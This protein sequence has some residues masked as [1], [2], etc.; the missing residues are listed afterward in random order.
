MIVK[1]RLLRWLI[2]I[3][4]AF[5]LFSALVLSFAIFT[6]LPDRIGWSALEKAVRSAGGTVTARREGA[7]ISGL[8][9]YDFDLRVP[10][11]MSLRSRR[12]HLRLSPWALVIGVARI[13]DLKVEAPD[14]SITP[15]PPSPDSKP[16]RN[17][18]WLRLLIP[19]LKVIDGRVTVLPTPGSGGSPSQWSG[20]QLFGNL[21]VESQRLRLT[22]TELSVQCPAPCPPALTVRGFVAFELG[23]GGQCDLRLKAGKSKILAKGRLRLK[24]EK[25]R[26]YRGEM[27]LKG[28]SLRE[29]FPASEG[30]PDLVL[31][32]PMA[33]DGDATGL[34]WKGDTTAR[35][36]GSA[37]SEGKIRW[38][39]GGLTLSSTAST[40]G[41][42]L[43]PIW[44]PT[45]E[46]RILCRGEGQWGLEI[47]PGKPI[48]WEA[49]A[50]AHNAIFM[51]VPVSEASLVSRGDGPRATIDGPFVTTLTGPGTLKV[52]WDVDPG[53]WSVEVTG[54]AA[55]PPEALSNWGIGILSPPPRP[56]HTPLGKWEA[57]RF[58]IAGD[59]LT[60]FIQAEARD[61]CGGEVT[62][63]MPPYSGKGPVTWSAT[64]Q[65]MDPAAW[66]LGPHGSLSAHVRFDGPDFD[67]GV[68]AFEIGAGSWGGVR[69]QPFPARLHFSPDA[70]KLE[71]CSLST[72]A[73]QSRVSG[74]LSGGE[75]INAEVEVT[76]PDLSLLEPFTGRKDVK[77]ELEGK[78]AL[79]GP[80]SHPDLRGHA[81]AR[82]A[83][84]G[85][86]AAAFASVDG[87]LDLPGKA[88]DLQFFWKD[89]AVTET[90]LGDGSATVSGPFS[91]S[92]LHLDTSAGE[93][94]KLTVDGRGN[95]GSKS[96]DLRLTKGRVDHE[97]RT[98]EQEGEAR[99]AWDPTAVTCSNL[100][101]RKKDASLVLSASMGLGAPQA[102]ISGTLTARH[103][104]LRLF[105]IPPTAGTLDGF[106]EADLAWSGTVENPSITGTGSLEEGSYRYPRSDLAITPIVLKVRARGNRLVLTEA[107]AT[108]AEGG[109]ATGS[110]AVHFRGFIPD[111]FDLKAV[112][113]DFPFL[114]GHDVQ[115][116][117]D[118]DAAFTGTPPH[119]ILNGTA[120]VLKGKIQLPEVVKQ[121]PLPSTIRFVNG[122]SEAASKVSKEPAGPQRLSGMLRLE[123]DGKLWVSNQSLLAELAGAL[124]IGFTPLGPTLAGRL[125]VVEG[126]YL[127]R[128]RKFD[129]RDSRI[130]FGGTTDLTPQVDIRALYRAGDW[131]ITVHLT[132][133]PSKPDLGLSSSPPLPREDILSLLL[134]GTTSSELSNLQRQTTDRSAAALAQQ[135]GTIPLAGALGQSI[136]LD[137]VEVGTSSVGFSKYMGD[138]L[139]LEYR[140]IFGAL[141]EQRIDLRYRINRRWSFETQISN[142]GRSGADILWEKRY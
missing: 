95:L 12:I 18:R 83:S 127:F 88:A 68:L 27:V 101:I 77:G 32:G 118:F 105:P 23:R 63:Q 21:S 102:P 47:F 25:V 135:Y 141:P 39:Q 22:L 134:F 31:D 42:N 24:N 117:C 142:A 96:G 55:N 64:A 84:M 35:T 66:G 128:G 112:G 136:G 14:L 120:R 110:G 104:P 73:G 82:R 29:I 57:R 116:R 131:E 93:G 44:N 43:T 113:R 103:L 70:M 108:T 59:D 6:P 10:G 119:P 107:T 130:L 100:G 106:I 4:A 38:D 5:I 16:Y 72:S 133:N 115:G 129:L 121:A 76:V 61:P 20:L 92:R 60:F 132:G 26:D 15:G 46:K 30:V 114:L 138:R 69:Y 78:V 51:D 48:R 140:Q 54:S 41:F 74:T 125:E 53:T 2:R 81:T 8:D 50:R 137:S 85:G 28:F 13:K 19:G 52:A 98:F 94:R 80:V 17:P 67:R 89:L 49:S 139:V 37:K 3:V 79:S 124:D 126:R 1:S 36:Y 111:S 109:K 122:P 7:L 58:V 97:G 62:F 45:P 56:L 33:M 86:L 40:D 71:P 34:S 11:K 65:G 123:S 9:L 75:T 91:D 87:S 99:L 90:T